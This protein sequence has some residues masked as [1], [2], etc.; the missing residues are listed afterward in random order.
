MTPTPVRTS[1]PFY[2][3]DAIYAQPGAL[4]L[5]TRGNET[6][7]DQAATRLRSAERVVVTGIGSSWH[8]ALV[9]ETWLA[10]PDR[11]GGR[12]HAV[13]GFELA[14]YGP[15]IDAKT[16]VVV[17]SHAGGSRY[18]KET[19]A[20]AKKAGASVIAVTGKGHD[21]FAGAD[22]IVRTVDVESSNTHTVGYTTA[23][24]ML[25]HLAAKVGDAELARAIDGLPDHLATLLGQESW[26]D[27]VRKYGDKRRFWFLGGGPNRAT[28][29][30]AAMKMSEATYANATGYE[31][32]QF[33]HGL[34]AALDANDLVVL[35]APPGASH[36]R[37]VVAARVA[38]EIGAT[39]LAL[40]AETDRELG[41]L[42]T[43]T[44]ALP[45][46]SEPVS[47]I[48]AIIPLQLFTYHLAV[49]RGVNP[50][51]MRTDEAAYARARAALSL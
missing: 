19:L 43:E 29:Y 46:V 7:L 24:A 45:D 40:A 33:L 20:E 51:T 41:G 50:D 2:M 21:V 47:P 4:R 34:W 10:Q 39:V 14:A 30:E 44:I 25:G 17:V 9:A 32:E 16:A 48:A 26:D 11:L 13:H 18:L 42:A 6:A 36:A 49:A 28:A 8:A 12:V 15:P 3:H 35:V 23:L 37:L 27:L 22:V 1:H 38:R 31:V 5:V